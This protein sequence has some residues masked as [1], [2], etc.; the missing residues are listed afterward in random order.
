[1]QVFPQAFP[2]EQTL[3]QPPLAKQ[4]DVEAGPATSASNR[5]AIRIDTPVGSL[6]CPHPLSQ[7]LI[8]LEDA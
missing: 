6:C 5:I 3:Q 4:T 8:D 7:D 1:M 2:A